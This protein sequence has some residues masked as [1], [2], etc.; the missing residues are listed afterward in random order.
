[1]AS[2]CV[3]G[4]AIGFVLSF[5]PDYDLQRSTSNLRDKRFTKP[6][7]TVEGVREVAGSDTWQE[8]EEGRRMAKF[9]AP[10]NLI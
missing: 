8:V 6:C 1:M 2:I 4:A 5:V 9:S 7:G 10:R 3:K